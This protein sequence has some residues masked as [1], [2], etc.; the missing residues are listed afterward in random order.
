MSLAD[1]I[2]CYPFTHGHFG[3]FPYL[4]IFILQFVK[5]GT[6]TPFIPQYLVAPSAVKKAKLEGSLFKFVVKQFRSPS[7]SGVI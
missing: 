2:Q 1:L 5:T 3:V 4:V 7:N 6:P